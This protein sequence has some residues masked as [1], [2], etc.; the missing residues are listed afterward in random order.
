MRRPEIA[1]RVKLAKTNNQGKE[2][3]SCASH[4]LYVPLPVFAACS[5]CQLDSSDRLVCRILPYIVVICWVCCSLLVYAVICR[6]LSS[7]MSSASNRS[8][9]WPL[10]ARTRLAALREQK[11]QRKAAQ[12]RAFWPDIKVALESGH[13]YDVIC[14]C[15]EAAGV[16]VTVKNLSSYVS[17][18]R[19]TEGAQKGE[20]IALS[21]DGTNSQKPV[22][23]L[24]TE[25]GEQ[26]RNRDPLANLREREASRSIF[27]Y[28][29]ELADPKKLI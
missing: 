8:D 9:T 4:F 23:Q 13:S 14:E 15:L 24:G 19:K 22:L 25:L 16:S 11:P 28:R 20:T 5:V 26:S 2:N 29:P 21:P 7:V 6:K 3:H 12:I 17:R 1:T 18:I 10:A 27:D